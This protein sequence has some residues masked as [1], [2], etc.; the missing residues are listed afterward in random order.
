MVAMKAATGAWMVIVTFGNRPNT[1]YGEVPSKS[2]AKRLREDAIRMGYRDARVAN[3]EEFRQECFAKKAA[4]HGGSPAAAAVV[5]GETR[6]VHDL[7]RVPQT[8]ASAIPA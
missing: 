3:A 4:S 8:S 2:G 1:V 5:G 7:R 6:G